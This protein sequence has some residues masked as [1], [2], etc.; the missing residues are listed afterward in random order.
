MTHTLANTTL[1]PAGQPFQ[2]ACSVTPVSGA[3]NATTHALA[4]GYMRQ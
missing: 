2:M 3:V 4:K 1:I